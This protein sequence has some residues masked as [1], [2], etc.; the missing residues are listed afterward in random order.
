MI[1]FGWGDPDDDFPAFD[2]SVNTPREM[3]SMSWVIHPMNWKN[4]YCVHFYNAHTWIFSALMNDHQN[5]TI[6][7]YDGLG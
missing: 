7:D 5:G 6:Y 1:S 4:H 3:N 2:D